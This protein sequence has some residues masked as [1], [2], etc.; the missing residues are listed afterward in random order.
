MVT[1]YFDNSTKNRY[2]PNPAKA[3]R[4]GEPTYD[5]MM[6][7]WMDYMA[8]KEIAKPSVVSKE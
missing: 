7:G 1:G 8:D 5:E 6:I 3:V 4:Y 2:N